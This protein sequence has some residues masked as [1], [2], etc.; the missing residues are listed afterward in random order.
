[1]AGGRNGTT[2]SMVIIKAGRR[3]AV[4]IGMRRSLYSRMASANLLVAGVRQVF[5][6]DRSKPQPPHVMY[7]YNQNFS[8]ML[9]R[10][11]FPCMERIIV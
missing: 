10:P 9:D 1:M 2:R 4:G 6:A 11:P 8:Y 3:L 5:R 7:N